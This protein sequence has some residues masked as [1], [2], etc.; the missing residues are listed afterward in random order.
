VHRLWMTWALGALA[1]AFLAGSASAASGGP[2]QDKV[3]VGRDQAQST[4]WS[5][6]V[7]F[8]RTFTNAKGSWIQ[9]SADCTGVKG[10]QETVAAFWVGLDG[11]SS[12]TVEQTGVD[13][14]CAGQTAYYIPWYEFYPSRTVTLGD[15]VQPGDSL[16]AAVSQD[17]AVVTVTLTDVTQGWTETA[18]TAASGLAFSSAE[19]IAEAPTHLLTDFG[20]VDF[21][22]A[23][24]TDAAG[25]GPIDGGDWSFDSI[26]M[27]G[28]QGPHAAVRAAPSGLTDSAGAS[29]FSITWLHS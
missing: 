18:T 15:T 17:G 20:V 26:T 29:A 3:R 24:A 27:V 19:W 10:H 28:H 6:Y 11:W 21:S 2:A 13:A 22:S 8:G 1:F 16:S 25:S 9:P 14:I 5:G 7:A 12:K 23:T 4:N